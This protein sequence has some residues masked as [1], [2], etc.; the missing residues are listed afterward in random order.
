MI[1]QGGSVSYTVTLR[2]LNGF[3]SPVSL[4]LDGL[5]LGASS[6]FDPPSVVPDGA[7]T[8]TVTTASSTP[9]GTYV[10]NVIGTG[11]GVTHLVSVL[12]LVKAVFFAPYS[13]GT[14][15]GSSDTTYRFANARYY[16]D[17]NLFDG[18]GTTRMLAQAW[19]GGGAKAMAYFRL[20]SGGEC[21]SSGTYRIDASFTI[22][23]FMRIMRVSLPA[24]FGYV[25]GQAIL[26]ASLVVYDVTQG[27]EVKKAE[28]DIFNE[29]LGMFPIPSPVY[30]RTEYYN[31]EG[32]YI[33][34]FTYLEEGHE[35]HWSFEVQMEGTIGTSGFVVAWAQGNIDTKLISVSIS[36][37]MIV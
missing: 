27:K 28:I 6:E 33:E 3:S 10:L 1:I 14:H 17:H 13:G 21:G 31:Q 5:P 9:F 25:F 26:K 23:G 34:V 18:S 16:S 11:D 4:A 30:Q 22:D 35:Y 37:M 24:K 7:S 20:F 19:M 36:P 2:S 32:R 29:K 15:G 12:L 8:L